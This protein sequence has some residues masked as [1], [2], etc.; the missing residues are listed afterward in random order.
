MNILGIDIGGSSLKAAPVN[1]V[2]GTLTT[3]RLVVPT[4]Q[5]ATPDAVADTVNEV[6][7]AFAWNG[8]VGCGF[9]AVIRNGIAL[10]AA[11]IDKSWINRDVEQLF[12]SRT[13]REI[14]VFNDADTAGLAEMAFG[15]GRNARGT[16][17]V[18]TAGTGLGTA[19]FRD[20]TLVPNCE[21]GHLKLH[22]DDAEKYASAAVRTRLKLSYHDWAKRFDD[23]LLRLEE[24]F[25]P[26]L[27]VIGGAI[28]SEHKQFLPLL[29]VTTKVL[30][31]E[32]R[33][34]AG[35]IG[36]ATAALQ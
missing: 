8:L 2:D 21:L 24:L 15:A 29:S 25:W 6:I 14:R 30:P 35:I 22:G 31:A 3:E 11:N 34:D 26:D 19:L 4:P 16:T 7:D 20:N 18:V 23:Y 27:F 33:N 28:S 9:P 32:L 36:A 12:L 13:G 5:P 17:I 10:T 1:P